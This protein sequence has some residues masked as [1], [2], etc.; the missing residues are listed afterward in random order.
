MWKRSHLHKLKISARA[1]EPGGQEVFCLTKAFLHF[2]MLMRSCLELLMERAVSPTPA[3][4]F[5][6]LSCQLGHDEAVP[7]AAA[8]GSDLYLADRVS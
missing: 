2:P 1:W 3:A 4:L 8:L 5:W 7:T 6:M